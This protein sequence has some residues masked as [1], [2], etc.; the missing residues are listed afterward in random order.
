MTG[1]ETEVRFD[2]LQHLIV[3]TEQDAAGKPKRRNCKQ[4]FLQGKQDMKTVFLCEK[5]QVPL[6]TFCFKGRIL[7]F[8]NR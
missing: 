2:G 1:P 4:C 7:D 8:L 5:C 3:S 6:H